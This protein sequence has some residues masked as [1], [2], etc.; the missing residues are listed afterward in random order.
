M[1]ITP[2]RLRC[3]R[4]TVTKLDLTHQILAKVLIEYEG[5]YL[6]FVS[7]VLAHLAK[8]I[9]LDLLTQLRYLWIVYLGCVALKDDW[10]KVISRTDR[11][12]WSLF[13]LSMG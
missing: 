8:C 11:C 13:C 3:K 12:D 6:P 9:H 4:A 2:G 1:L 10:V 7:E 5:F